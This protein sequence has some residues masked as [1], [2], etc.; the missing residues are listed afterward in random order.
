MVFKLLL[1]TVGSLQRRC[2]KRLV[3]D[4]RKSVGGDGWKRE[5]GREQQQHFENDSHT[6]T[7][8]IKV[9]LTVKTSKSK[10][11]RAAIRGL[12]VGALLLQRRGEQWN[13]AKP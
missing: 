4:R 6:S 5:E 3:V 12:K 11:I 8:T 2:R 9:I 13:H 7:I 1:S 10:L